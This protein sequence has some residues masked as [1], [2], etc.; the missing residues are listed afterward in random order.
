MNSHSELSDD[1]F[2]AAFQNCGLDPALFNHEAHLR[3]AW[4]HVTKYGE[5][6]AIDNITSQL[7]SFVVSLGAIH[8]YNKTLT[9]AAIKA[10][11]HFIGRSGA[12]NFDEF[13]QQFPRLKFNFKELMG[14]H[15]GIDIFNSA[16][17][18]QQY[19]EPDLLPFS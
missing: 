6:K 15:Y 2:E 5:A 10:V 11:N 13:I 8:K 19:L 4:I 17:A 16:I 7:F 14:S 3:L 9:I 18:K 1:R 12:D